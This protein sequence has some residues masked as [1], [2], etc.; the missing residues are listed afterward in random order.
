[1]LLSQL[2]AVKLR[3]ITARFVI[4]FNELKHICAKVARKFLG[5]SFTAGHG[6]EVQVSLAFVFTI[7]GFPIRR[8]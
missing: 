3:V 4:E 5:E 1:L 7:L 6:V 8:I 2:V